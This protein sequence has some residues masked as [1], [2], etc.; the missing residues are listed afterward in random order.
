[1]LVASSSS[2]NWWVNKLFIILLCTGTENRGKECI[3]RIL[4]TPTLCWHVIWSLVLIT[5]AKGGGIDGDGGKELPWT[6]RKKR[7]KYKILAASPFNNIS[8]RLRLSWGLKD[9]KLVY[10]C[11]SLITKSL[12]NVSVASHM[13]NFKK[14]RESIKNRLTHQHKLNLAIN[15][16]LQRKVLCEMSCEFFALTLSNN[17]FYLFCC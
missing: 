15:E 7:K 4:Y 1:M 17:L 11:G 5:R 10:V 16:C 6:K 3:K 9:C 2:K 8:T 14:E 13:I 12:F